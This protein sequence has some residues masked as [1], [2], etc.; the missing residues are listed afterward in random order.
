M[1]LTGDRKEGGAKPEAVSSSGTSSPALAL[2]LSPQG[3]SKDLSAEPP[4]SLLASGV[5]Q[6]SP[7]LSLLLWLLFVANHPS[8]GMLE[9]QSHC[10]PPTPRISRLLCPGS[11]T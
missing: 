4:T 2:I 8:Y 9:I 7:R 11:Q 6:M 10:H 3:T 5:D 1:K